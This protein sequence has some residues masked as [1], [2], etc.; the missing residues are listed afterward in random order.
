[1]PELRIDGL[2][3]K[4]Q[5][6]AGLD[7]TVLWVLRQLL[8]VSSPETVRI[9]G[10]PAPN[11]EEGRTTENSCHKCPEI[12]LGWCC[13]APNPWGGE[14]FPCGL[15]QYRPE[16]AT[17]LPNYDTEQLR[18]LH[19]GHAFHDNAIRFKGC[20]YQE[21]KSENRPGLLVLQPSIL[22][23]RRSL[24]CSST[25]VKYQWPSDVSHVSTETHSTKRPSTHQ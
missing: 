24:I 6:L 17:D 2:F 21:G 19:A 13:R 16:R 7:D 1:M 8:H 18:L 5:R 22:P 15:S 20:Y 12:S 3:S 25:S 11:V 4:D 14:D 23:S 10:L 9:A